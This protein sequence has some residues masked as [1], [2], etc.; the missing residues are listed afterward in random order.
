MVALHRNTSGTSG[1]QFPVKL[2]QDGHGS[3]EVSI[4]HILHNI[5]TVIK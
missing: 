4:E 3:S 5:V 1:K 2:C